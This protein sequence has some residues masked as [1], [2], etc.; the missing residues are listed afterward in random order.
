MAVTEFP[1]SPELVQAQAE[2]ARR[3]AAAYDEKEG[4]LK[5]KQVG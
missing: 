2:L 1:A 4:A 5:V 3:A